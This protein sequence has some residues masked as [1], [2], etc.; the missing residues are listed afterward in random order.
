MAGLLDTRAALENEMN[1]L[2]EYSNSF[3]AGLESFLR[4]AL[5]DDPLGKYYEVQHEARL[6]QNRGRQWEL[7]WQKFQSEMSQLHSEANRLRVL[8]TKRYHVEF[9]PL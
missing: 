1:R 5:G 2:A 8:L 6:L 4:T 3:E 9:K 7:E